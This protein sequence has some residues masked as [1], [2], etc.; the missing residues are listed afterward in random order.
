MRSNWVGFVIGFCLGI[1]V[2]IGGLVMVNRVQPAPIIIEAAP[3]PPLPEPTATP[4]LLR[5][6]VNGQVTVPDVYWLPPDSIVQAAIAAAGG[7]AGQADTAV[8]NLAHPLQDGMQIYVPAQG[9]QADGPA[10][11]II[12]PVGVLAVMGET[13]VSGLGDGLININTA[14]LAQLETLPGIG[15]STAQKIIEHRESSGPF[16]TIEAIMDVSGIG[17]AKF[18]A[19]KELITAGN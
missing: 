9:E 10:S 19:I 17:P 4:G 16:A 3:P 18:G 14:T 6:Y 7:F 13:A 12:A 2:G 11:G 1:I 8:I 5:V 15:P